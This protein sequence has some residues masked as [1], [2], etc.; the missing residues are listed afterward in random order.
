MTVDNKQEIAV[1]A[2]K[3]APPLLV[4]GT[5]TV[6]GFTLN[7]W[8]SILT[9]IYIVLQVTYLLHKWFKGEPGGEPAELPD[10]HDESAPP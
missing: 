7:D 2:V 5:H 6:L 4:V 3:T 9:I 1:A 8:V 10:R